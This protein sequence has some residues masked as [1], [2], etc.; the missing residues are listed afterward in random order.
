MESLG[1]PRVNFGDETLTSLKRALLGLLQ[2]DLNFH[3]ISFPLE[4]HVVLSNFTVFSCN[5]TLDSSD[6]CRATTSRRNK[7]RRLSRPRRLFAVRQ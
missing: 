2:S 3:P 1:K 7:R 6:R 4:G 5:V